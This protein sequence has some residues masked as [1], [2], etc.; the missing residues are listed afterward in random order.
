M[1]GPGSDAPLSRREL[2]E[3]RERALQQEVPEQRQEL[4]YFFDVPGLEATAPATP[5]AVEPVTDVFP[6][7]GHDEPDPATELFFPGGDEEPAAAPKPRRRA[8]VAGVLGELL[9]TAGVIVLLFV[10][11][12]MWVGDLIL[13]AAENVKAGEQSQQWQEELPPPLPEST[14]NQNG[15]V[16]FEP[17]VAARPKGTADFATIIIPRF[18][19]DYQRRVAGGTTRAGTLD[20][21]RFGLYDQAAMPG[22]V[23]NFALAAHRTTFGG[24]LRHIDSLRLGDAIII[25]MKEG[26]YLYRFRSLEYVRPD[27]VQ[28]LLDVPQLPG[29]KTGERFITLTS[30]SPLH[31]L[32]ER[33]IAYGL[34]ESFQPRAEGPPAWLTE[35]EA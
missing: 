32:E 18:G 6:P 7:L 4:P 28:V 9:L 21:E 16:V 14:I 10:V 25:E 27:R 35:R 1:T 22:E 23:G 30:C 24:P 12:Q 5:P 3:Q 31:S 29:V 34:F 8:S 17:V 19:D 20:K 11:W 13:G 33:I 15:E 2:R 26:W